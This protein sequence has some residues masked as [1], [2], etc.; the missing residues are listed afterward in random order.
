MSKRKLLELVEGKYVSGWDDPRMP[1][2][3]GLR[4]RGY[5]PESIRDFCD[6]VG[7]AKKEN[8]IDVEVLEHA[9]REDLNRRAPRAMCVLKPLRL[10]IDNYP[11]GRV[12]EMEAVNN[13]ENPA[14]GTRKVPFSGELFI[15]QE[16]FSENPPPKYHR[17]APGRT[18]RLRYSY[19]VTCTRSVKDEKGKVV[20]VHC[21]YHPASLGPGAEGVPKA[22]ATIHWVSAQHAARI[23]ARLYD[24]LFS[25]E[26]PT[27]ERGGND[28][29]SYLNPNSLEVLTGCRAEPSLLSS[30]PGDRFQFERMGYFCVDPDSVAGAPAFNRTVTL[31]DT[32]AKIQKAHQHA[33]AP[34]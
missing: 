23:E 25:V 32:W 34:P 27:N 29:K 30:R 24:R 18:V 4:R 10:V 28:W 17:L 14:S 26:D 8:V 2:I 16:D 22:K 21:T 11:E 13:P 31:K 33:G 20:E 3:C 5:T 12:E 19:L 7:V 1:T 9:A 15:E 6:R